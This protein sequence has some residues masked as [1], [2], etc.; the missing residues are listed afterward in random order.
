VKRFDL[1]V[2]GCALS[3]LLLSGCAQPVD[4][5][6]ISAWV[7]QSL[8]EKCKTDKDY[9]GIEVVEV[10]LV[11]ESPN[12]FTG[13]VEFRYE[14]E[15]DRPDLVVTVDHDSRI[16]RCE[17][18]QALMMK[19]AMKGLDSLRSNPGID[20]GE[21][22]RTPN[23]TEPEQPARIQSNDAEAWVKRGINHGEAGQ[24]S[25]AI[26][27]FQ[28]AIK[29]KPDYARAWDD[30][31]VAYEKSGQMDDAIGAYRQAIKIKPN[32]AVFWLDLGIT[33][34]EAGRTRDAIEASRQAIK[35]KPDYWDAW[36]NLDLMCKRSS[37]TNDAV[38][39]FT[40]A[41]H[42]LGLM[43][44]KS[45]Q[46]DNAIGAYR[47]AIKIKPDDAGVWLDLGVACLKSGRTIDAVEAFRQAIKIKP[48]YEEAL[49]NLVVACSR[50]NQTDDV[51]APAGGL[52]R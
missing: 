35:I 48:D 29:I 19:R 45:G 13:Y 39:A 17:P 1:F 5:D 28:Q 37:Q 24:F 52:S 46:M 40:E 33:Y 36:H 51:S 3:V 11:R 42:N 16:Y 8:T 25:D 23:L 21:S 18:P 6:E 41:W 22:R 26:E 4:K 32:D 10:A 47:E 9:A 15:V 38:E 12:K 34:G 2:I 14:G 30:L 27:D 7:K 50:S 20:H 43:Y 31:G 44:G 49:S